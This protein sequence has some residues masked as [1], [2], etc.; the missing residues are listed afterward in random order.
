[1]AT[2]KDIAA[3]SGLSIATDSKRIN[4]IPVSEESRR[5]SEGSTGSDAAAQSAVMNR[6]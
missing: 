2:I 5:R 1:M 4:G 3:R 6:T